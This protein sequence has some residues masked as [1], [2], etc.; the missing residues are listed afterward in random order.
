MRLVRTDFRDLL[1]LGW[2]DLADMLVVRSAL[3][4]AADGD[5]N[6]LA[7]LRAEGRV[8]AV[9]DLAEVEVVM[10]FDRTALVAF[11]DDDGAKVECWTA[12]A[13]VEPQ[14]A[15]EGPAEGNPHRGTTSRPKSPRY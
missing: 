11:H 10:A 5:A 13:A 12:L 2:R 8:M 1:P 6:P 7:G 15:E 9:P 14:E 4:S 3:E